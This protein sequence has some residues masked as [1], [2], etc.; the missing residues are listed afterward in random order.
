M[1]FFQ[2]LTAHLNLIPAIAN[3]VQAFQAIGHSKESTLAKVLQIIEVSANL[4]ET[5][6]VPVV[7]AVSATV[8]SIVEQIFSP[9]TSAAA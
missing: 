5:I 1:T 6:P 3:A 4:G 8:A 2:N 9:A 7:A